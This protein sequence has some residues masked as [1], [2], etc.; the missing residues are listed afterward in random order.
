M[1]FED[2]SDCDQFWTKSGQNHSETLDVARNLTPGVDF[3]V[4]K[5]LDI[6]ESPFTVQE[7]NHPDRIKKEHKV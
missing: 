6:T 3:I 1:L 5:L 4:K 7:S 2:N